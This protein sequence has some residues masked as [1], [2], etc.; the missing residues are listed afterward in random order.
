MMD[1]NELRPLTD[2]EQRVA[3]AVRRTFPPDLVLIIIS[4]ALGAF[5]RALVNGYCHTPT[6]GPEAGSGASYCRSVADASSW[7]LYVSAGILIAVFARF[8][9]RRLHHARLIAVAAVAI[10]LIVNTVIIYSLP[11]LGP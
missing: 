11:D 4:A 3:A 1:V 7:L 9:F 2:R 10:A 5:G 8:V 6:G